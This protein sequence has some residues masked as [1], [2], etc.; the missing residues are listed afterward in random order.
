[1]G[2][3]SFEARLIAILRRRHPAQAGRMPLAD[4]VKAIRHQTDRARDHGL[5][6]E[7][8]AATYVHTAWLLGDGFDRRIPAI[9]QILAEPTLTAADKARAL[10][11]FSTLVFRALA[12][13]GTDAPARSA[14]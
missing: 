12:G 8:S 3:A 14:A 2:Q 13:A 5:S 10:T 4:L 6:D 1:M 7:H 9:A 11:D